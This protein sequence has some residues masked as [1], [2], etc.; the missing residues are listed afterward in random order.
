M[1]SKAKV[2]NSYA[3]SIAALRALKRLENCPILP[4]S[5]KW[6]GNN[7]RSKKRRKSGKSRKNGTSES[8]TGAQKARKLSIFRTEPAVKTE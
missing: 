1:I 4:Q 5:Q 2:Y 7:E 8:S 3:K 6:G